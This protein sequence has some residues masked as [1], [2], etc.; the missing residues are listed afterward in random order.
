MLNLV[1]AVGSAARA[2]HDDAVPTTSIAAARGSDR[3]ANETAAAQA[4]LN[5]ANTATPKT[6]SA[7]QA[8]AAP[9]PSSTS[10]GTPQPNPGAWTAKIHWIPTFFSAEV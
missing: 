8:S 6:A 2:S 7:P 3:K 5:I 4:A 10:A 1:P 9:L